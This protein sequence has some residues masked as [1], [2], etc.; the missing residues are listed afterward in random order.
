MKYGYVF[1]TLSSKKKISY[2][3]A[4]EIFNFLALLHLRKSFSSFHD[5]SILTNFPWLFR[6]FPRKFIFSGFSISVQTLKCQQL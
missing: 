4:L 1:E 5:F 3:V 2:G 6:D